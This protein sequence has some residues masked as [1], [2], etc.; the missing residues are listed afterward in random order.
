VIGLQFHLELDKDSL[1]S[2]VKVFKEQLIQD[3]YVHNEGKINLIT[4][5]EFE[6]MQK[7][8]VN[9]LNYLFNK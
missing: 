1:K 9:L 2:L 8:L 7:N 5:E 6:I 3:Q 4:D